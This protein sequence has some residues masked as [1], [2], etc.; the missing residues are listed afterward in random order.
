M[1]Q[2]PL[3]T[4]P[5]II[6][7]SA[8]ILFFVVFFYLL[9]IQLYRRRLIHKKEL[10]NLR[11]QFEQTILQSRLEI[12]EQ[13][14]RNI[15][16]EIHDN[17]GQV[18]SLAKLNLNM[19]N[20]GDVGEKIAITE[21]LL[22]KAISDLRDLSKSLNGDKITDMGIS[23]A[24]KHEL[25]LITKTTPLKTRM[26]SAGIEPVLT[27]EQTIIVFRMIQ[28]I[29]NNSIKHGKAKEILVEIT[30]RDLFSSICVADDGVGFDTARLKSQE[31]GIGLKSIR[32]RSQL[33]NARLNI[34][35]SPGMGTRVKIELPQ[36]NKTEDL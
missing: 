25:E 8:L 5:F 20:Q 33:I 31:T 16:M 14:F 30:T 34:D 26:I 9:F 10:S 1:L 36:L 4:E 24:I 6:I 22:G 27:N 7:G 3:Y 15:S 19:I 32:H 17:I 23:E 28:E 13:T 35:S 11:L 2:A 21:E 29:F 18:L 12:Q